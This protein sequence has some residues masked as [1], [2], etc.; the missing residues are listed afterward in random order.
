VVNSNLFVK[1]N[2]V[3]QQSVLIGNNVF[4]DATYSMQCDKKIRV[5]GTD[6]LSDDRLKRNVEPMDTA[7]CLEDTLK[8]SVKRFEYARNVGP[9]V[10]GLIAQETERVIPEA[11]SALRGSIPV[12]PSVVGTA[13]STD[14]LLLVANDVSD[15]ERAELVEGCTVLV[16]EMGEGVLTEF[17]VREMEFPRMRIE[18][19]SRQTVLSA[20]KIYRVEE[21]RV[22]DLRS[23][24]Y[25]QLLCRLIGAVQELAKRQTT[26]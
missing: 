6:V 23:I 24:D 7:Q 9:K 2:G 8:L 17:T 10:T 12:R 25:T 4:Y 5:E 1:E 20:D 3:Y 11:I 16:R 14:T 18:S 19:T 26:H 22:D 13:I 15:I 21:V